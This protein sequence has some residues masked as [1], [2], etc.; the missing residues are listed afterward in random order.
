MVRERVQID[1]V[2][3]EIVFQPFHCDTGVPM[4]EE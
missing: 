4:D 2:V 3:S 1:R